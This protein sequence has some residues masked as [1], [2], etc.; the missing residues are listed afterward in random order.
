MLS[1]VSI[2]LLLDL[3]L[4]VELRALDP[5]RWPVEAAENHHEYRFYHDCYHVQQEVR[6]LKFLVVNAQVCDIEDD[7]DEEEYG[8][9]HPCHSTKSSIRERIT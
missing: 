1:V 8:E 7:V 2:L 5:L 6:R 9:V 3:Y 4:E